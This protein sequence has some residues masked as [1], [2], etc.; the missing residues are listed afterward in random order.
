MA[1][2]GREFGILM[3][4]G[5]EIPQWPLQAVVRVLV[6]VGFGIPVVEVC[7]FCEPLLAALPW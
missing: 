1:P 2:S 4:V 7:C 3:I 5:F 6:E